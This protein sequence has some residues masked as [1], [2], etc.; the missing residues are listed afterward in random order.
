MSR[1]A[2]TAAFLAFAAAALA[3][4]G[5]ASSRNPG[6][7]PV[8]VAAPPDDVTFGSSWFFLPDYNYISDPVI[9]TIPDV[10]HVH[11]LFMMHRPADAVVFGHAFT[12][13]GV[14]RLSPGASAAGIFFGSPDGTIIL[15]ITD[16]RG[17]EVA[18]LART[19]AGKVVLLP[20]APRDRKW[21]SAG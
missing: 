4:G 10:H 14:E 6:D 9:G 11:T 18:R 19:R 5:C 8:P 3:F 21:R 17:T 16:E 12:S 13:H 20:A 2:T 15:L 1:A 7:N